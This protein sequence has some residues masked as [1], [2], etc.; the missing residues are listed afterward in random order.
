MTAH[1]TLNKVVPSCSVPAYGDTRVMVSGVI[2]ANSHDT[3][4]GPFDV[5]ANVY[6]FLPLAPGKAAEALILALDLPVN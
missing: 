5:L 3:C 4:H 1:V 2:D 6:D